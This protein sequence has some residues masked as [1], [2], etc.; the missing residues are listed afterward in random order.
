MHD[1]HISTPQSSLVLGAKQGPG[2][3]PQFGTLN[4]V[5]E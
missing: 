4:H 2:I 5:L 1:T 3:G